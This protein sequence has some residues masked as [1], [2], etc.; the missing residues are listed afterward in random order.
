V[1]II[2]AC[3]CLAQRVGPARPGVGR[4]RAGCWVRPAPSPPSRSSLMHSARYGTVARAGGGYISFCACWGR[5]LRILIGIGD[6]RRQRPWTGRL[7]AIAI[8]AAPPR[9]A[10]GQAAATGLGAARGDAG[11]PMRRHYWSNIKGEMGGAHDRGRQKGE[12]MTEGSWRPRTA[13]DW[14]PS[15]RAG[16]RAAGQNDSGMQEAQARPRE[17]SRSRRASELDE[18]CRLIASDG[19]RRRSISTSSSVRRSRPQHG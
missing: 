16:S 11:S 13:P 17:N 10:T 1:S 12:S 8:S 18:G 15:G 4:R 3:L 5:V 7:R 6:R 14:T 19:Y 9:W 2:A